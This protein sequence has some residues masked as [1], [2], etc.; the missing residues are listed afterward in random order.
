MAKDYYKI[1]GIARNAAKDEIKRAYRALAHKFHPDKG[2]D[3]ERFK[4]VN[5]A[6]RVLSDD[7]KRSQYDQ[8][9]QVFEGA[10]G[11]GGFQGGFEWPG[12]FKFDFGSEGAGGE[13]DFS[14]VFEDFFGGGGFGASTRAKTRGRKGKDVRIELSIQFKE[15]VFGGKETVDISK[16]IRC[17]RCKGS[18]GEPGSKETS[19]K[20]CQGKG[21]VQ[22]IQ[23][24]FL[25]S[26]TAVSTCPDCM[27]TGKRPETLCAGC[28]G[29]G[30]VRSTETLEIFVPRGVRDGEILK[31]TGK[32]EASLTGSAPGDLYIKIRVLSH[33]IFQ[34]QGD[35]IVMQLSIPLTE[36]ILG[37]TKEVETLDGNIRLKIPEGTQPSDVLRV[38][39]KG[40]YSASGYG[41]GDLLIEIKVN[42]PKKISKKARETVE[43]LQ[44]EGL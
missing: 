16:L 13:F 19:C 5:E 28:R 21:N 6:Y 4:E 31:M 39:G 20:T 36:A 2:G 32:G 8:F 25:G 23:R 18:G 7:N 33:E 34:R 10:G 22:K 26:F 1:L 43:K 17:E 42:I 30:V 40:A 15:S 27:G 37:T 41:R 12:G 11:G 35:D 44:E 38:R 29:Q 9:G 3:G 14:D 24:T